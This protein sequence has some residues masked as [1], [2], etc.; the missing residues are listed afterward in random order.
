MCIRY[1]LLKSSDKRDAGHGSDSAMI[2][3]VPPDLDVALVPPVLAP[4]VLHK[5]VVEAG[6]G[7]IAVTHLEIKM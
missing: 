5:P 7:V 4:A 1:L 3:L 6:V 2:V